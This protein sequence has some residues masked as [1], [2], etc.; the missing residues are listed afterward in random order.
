[1]NFLIT[2]FLVV[3]LICCCCNVVSAKRDLNLKVIFQKT[4][5]AI[6]S[7]DDDR[8][9]KVLRKFY[10]TDKKED[11]VWWYAQTEAQ[12]E[13]NIELGVDDLLGIEKYLK[14]LDHHYTHCSTYSKNKR[15]AI[16]F[17][18][19]LR[20][21]EDG[22]RSFLWD[23]APDI[24]RESKSKWGTLYLTNAAMVSLISASININIKY[25]GDENIVRDWK[26]AFFQDLEHVYSYLYAYEKDV[27][28]WR[29]EQITS[30]DIC[31]NK[32]IFWKEFPQACE[33]R[34]RRS[35]DETDE[36]IEEETEVENSDKKSSLYEAIQEFSNVKN[37]TAALTDEEDNEV[38]SRND[39]P[40]LDVADR[41]GGTPKGIRFY[42]AKI[43]DD[44][45]KEVLYEKSI[46]VEDGENRG[47][48]LIR[49][50]A[51]GME[52][53]G[54]HQIKI[55]KE[56]K[57]YNKDTVFNVRKILNMEMLQLK[58]W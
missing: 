32:K 24:D 49:M 47:I 22:L 25:L 46:E 20:M 18:Q 26:V 37:L 10:F 57:K 54:K 34:W 15:R 41:I 29:R 33:T 3:L 43:I 38:D 5:R 21:F 2:T 9:E 40:S 14:N 45:T 6:K 12:K 44:V 30:M 50:H 17:H 13:F 19:F 48:H 42:S 1:M 56:V 27:I 7:Q 52:I 51:E 35:T 23:Y 55:V 16:C 58:S 31:E 4:R 36:E 39:D 53:R 11:S 28:R 8:I